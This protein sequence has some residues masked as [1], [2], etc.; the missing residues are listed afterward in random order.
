M[1]SFEEWFAQEAKE[2]KARDRRRAKR[3]YISITKMSVVTVGIMFL[4]LW[5]A[6]TLP[7]G[8]AESKK[9][10]FGTL[11]KLFIGIQ[12]FGCSVWIPRYKNALRRCKVILDAELAEDEKNRF[13]QEIMLSE[14]TKI[15]FIFNKEERYII[16]TQHYM[17]VKAQTYIL[18]KLDN[19][20]HIDV[21][22]QYKTELLTYRHRPK[23]IYYIMINDDPSRKGQKYIELHNGDVCNE[24]YNLIL[25]A[26]DLVH[27]DRA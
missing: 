11:I 8:D 3:E 14:A 16:L 2:E 6:C 22:T 1:D 27:S 5:A 17:L 21:K 15:N 7:E 9:N 19:I 18:A 20:V 25:Q 4:L 10:I 24:A 26:V 23:I 13:A 12:L